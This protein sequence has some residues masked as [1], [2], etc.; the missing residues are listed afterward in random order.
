[1]EGMCEKFVYQWPSATGVLTSW[2]CDELPNL[3]ACLPQHKSKRPKVAVMEMWWVE[4]RHQQL[5]KCKDQACRNEV[6]DL[7]DRIRDEAAAK[8]D[9]DWGTVG[10][11]PGS[12][13]KEKTELKNDE[14]PDVYWPCGRYPPFNMPGHPARP[15][16]FESCLNG[17]CGPPIE[18][19]WTAHRDPLD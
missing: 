2:K 18:K 3:E 16:T 6:N 10:T 15:F 12:R 11:G 5:K 1:M 7:Y 19:D 8:P 9:P 17:S 13:D 14:I 4:M